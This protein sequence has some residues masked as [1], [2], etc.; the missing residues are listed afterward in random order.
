[1]N[2]KV[3]YDF[4]EMISRAGTGA[5]KYE[6]RKALFG[7]EDVEPFWVAD[8]DLPTP[9][10]LLEAIAKRLCHPMLGYT[11]VSNRLLEAICWWQQSQH[12]LKVEPAWIRLSPSVVTSIAMGIQSLS[13]PGE[14][15]VIPSPVYGPFFFA[16]KNNGRRVIDSPMIVDNGQY[17]FDFVEL[18][19][20]LA[21]KDVTLL[22][23]CSP[24]NPGGRVWTKEELEKIVQLCLKH[25]VKIF[26]DEIHC[27]IVYSPFKHT[28]LLR[29]EGAS[30]IS[31]VAHSIG[32]TFNTSGLSASF[33]I[34]PNKQ[35]YVAF[36]QA[37]EKSHCGGVNL[38]GKVAMEA[39]FSEL[40]ENY[41]RQLNQY[42]LENTRSVV[43]ILGQLSAAKVM[44][45]QATFLVWFDMRAFG[46]W[47][48]VMKKLIHEANVALSGGPF[49]GPTGKG[50]FR[51]NC[52]HPQ[53]SL[54]AAARRIVDAFQ[55]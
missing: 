17:T 13:E 46:Q 1:M 55:D 41:K 32:K 31:V 19:K 36:E 10:F 27:D 21:P 3:K 43:E 48:T 44:E 45:P 29:I 39:A 37:A 16:A 35:L 50:F 11:D 22:M 51:I 40:G 33:V 23:L 4:N 24:H 47:P 18:E 12:R 53:S 6:A 49:F 14:G 54:F 26:C 34:I 30:E 52:A 15:V 7:K 38:L 25:G 28:S 9:A 42:L 5:E 20:I 2:T 8:M